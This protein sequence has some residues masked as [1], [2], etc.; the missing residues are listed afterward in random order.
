MDYRRF[1]IRITHKVYHFSAFYWTGI[2]DI[3]SSFSFKTC[4]ILWIEGYLILWIVQ[5][6]ILLGFSAE[7]LN[8]SLQP[9]KQRK[10][11]SS[12]SEI[13]FSTLRKLEKNNSTLQ[14]LCDGFPKCQLGK[15]GRDSSRGHLD[16]EEHQEAGE[17]SEPGV[18]GPDTEEGSLEGQLKQEQERGSC[19]C[20][21]VPLEVQG[22]GKVHNRTWPV[23]LKKNCLLYLISRHNGQ[24]EGRLSGGQCSYS[25]GVSLVPPDELYQL[26]IYLAQHMEQSNAGNNLSISCVCVRSAF[27]NSCLDSG[28]GFFALL[29]FGL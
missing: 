4:H 17:G 7:I 16:E 11:K 27:V 18:E 3:F 29:G 19:R 5:F 6:I 15:G 23:E 24:K 8:C 13:I 10:K 9:N 14:V 20:S 28:I 25:W 26:A 2:R 1:L 21:E 22:K 12:K